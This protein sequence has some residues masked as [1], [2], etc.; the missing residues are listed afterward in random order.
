MYARAVEEAASRLRQLRCEA[1][2]DVVLSA[3]ALGLVVPATQ[4]WPALAFPL[5]AGG[6]GGV[7]LAVRAFSRRWALI[8]RLTRERDAYVIRE[9]RARAAKAASRESRCT[10]AASIRSMEREPGLALA[11]RVAACAGELEALASELECPELILDPACAVQCIHLL[12]DGAGSPL[13]NPALPADDAC[14]RVRQIR[15]GF[16]GPLAV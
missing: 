4:L 9:V 5:F 13:L 15:A 2:G 10:L 3:L 12:T 11:D 7:V 1:L 16:E 6:I 8:E 14:A